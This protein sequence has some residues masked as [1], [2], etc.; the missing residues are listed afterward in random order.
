M[1][2]T[3]IK[4]RSSRVQRFE[5]TFHVL[6]V[7]LEHEHYIW[8]RWMQQLLSQETQPRMRG[9]SPK[10][11][12]PAISITKGSRATI[13]QTVFPCLRMRLMLWGSLLT[14]LRPDGGGRE[15]SWTATFN[16]HVQLFGGTKTEFSYLLPLASEEEQIKN[17]K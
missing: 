7:C 9:Q 15:E 1:K 5:V 13:E 8:E 11:S 17:F 16:E 12:Q 6:V 2:S 14:P 10:S 3:K 4:E